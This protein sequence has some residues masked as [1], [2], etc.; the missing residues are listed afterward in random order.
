MAASPASLGDAGGTAL[1]PPPAPDTW[2]LKA[3][4]WGSESGCWVPCQVPWLGSAC[5]VLCQVLCLGLARRVLCLGLLLVKA[6]GKH[7][8]A[9][10]LFWA[11]L[12]P[13]AGTPHASRGF[14]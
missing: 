3:Q 13:H 1:L 7:A 9:G 2:P 12:Q 4:L 14:F 8:V 6:L 11:T 5:W 10:L